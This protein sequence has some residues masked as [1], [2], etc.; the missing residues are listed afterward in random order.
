MAQARDTQSV[1]AH[2][3]PWYVNVYGADPTLEIATLPV[4]VRSSTSRS[5]PGSKR[6]DANRTSPPCV[7]SDR[8][9]GG[10]ASVGAKQ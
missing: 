8:A 5:Q 1:V 2:D 4:A 3:M 9:R 7:P 6:A 10:V